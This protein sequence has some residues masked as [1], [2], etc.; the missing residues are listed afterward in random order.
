MVTEVAL[1]VLHES[2]DD[3]PA[4]IDGGAAVKLLIAGAAALTV[5]VTLQEL[6]AGIA[7]PF[8]VTVALPVAADSVP[9]QVVVADPAETIPSLA[10]RLRENSEAPVLLRARVGE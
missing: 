5:T 6:L 10:G 9:P 1:A 4:V 2:V 8:K 3:P 7:P